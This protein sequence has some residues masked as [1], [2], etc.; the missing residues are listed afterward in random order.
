MKNVSSG[1][2]FSIDTMLSRHSWWILNYLERNDFVGTSALTKNLSQE[3]SKDMTLRLC[4]ADDSYAKN[5]GVAC[6]HPRGSAEDRLLPS[7]KIRQETN[8]ETSLYDT[9][10]FNSITSQEL[11]LQVHGRHVL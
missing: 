11:E 4:M 8:S 7:H 6:W 10:Q 1:I 2:E 9:Q 5:F 3:L